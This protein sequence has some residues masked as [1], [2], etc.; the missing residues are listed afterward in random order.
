PSPPVRLARRTPSGHFGLGVACPP[1]LYAGAYY[2][3]AAFYDPPVAYDPPVPSDPPMA[4]AQPP[5]Y[6]APQIGSGGVVAVAPVP[7]APPAPPT[8]NV[9]E[10][11]TG[12]YELRGDGITTPY[13]A[14]WIRTPPPRRPVAP[15]PPMGRS[16]GSTP[17]EPPVAR[18]SQ[19]YR[20]TDEQGVTHFTDRWEIVPEQ[21]RSQIKR[22][23][24]S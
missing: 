13:T 16:W 24:S 1:P 22:F 21:Y 18:R 11:P 20:W 23:P 17:D 8:P 15:P 12:R 10:Y 5:V 19:L 6:Y 14:V 9:V 4:Y 2:G 3:A 7:P